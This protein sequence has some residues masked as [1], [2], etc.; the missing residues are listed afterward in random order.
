MVSLTDGVVLLRPL[1]PADAQ[2]HLA[3]EDEE[4]VRWLNG[5]RSS[6]EGV[7]AHLVRAAAAWTREEPWRAFGV[8]D[9][10]S[11]RLAGTI[12]AHA[13]LPTLALGSVN[14]AYGIYPAW[15]RR[16]YATRAVRL[17]SAFSRDVLRCGTAVLRVAPENV[18]S[19]RVA[20]R[21]GFRYVGTVRTEEGPLRH[22]VRPT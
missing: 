12:D 20:L 19:I 22:Y 16:G 4:L 10:G 14:L 18:P 13:A 21:C 7:R 8:V 6:L 1:A 5:G 17:L 9:V 2:A 3:G 15:R 11:G